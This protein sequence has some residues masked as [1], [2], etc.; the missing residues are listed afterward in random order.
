MAKTIGSEGYD[1]CPVDAQLRD[2]FAGLAMQALIAAPGN[3]AANTRPDIADA[4]YSFSAAML[5]ARKAYVPVDH[6]AR[7]AADR[8]HAAMEELR[9]RS[10]K[11]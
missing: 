10:G 9:L 5:E 4:A 7:A 8:A 6:E 3:M 2:W 1:V 11:T